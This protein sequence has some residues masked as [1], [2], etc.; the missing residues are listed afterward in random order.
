MWPALRSSLQF[1]HNLTCLSSSRSLSGVWT[2]WGQRRGRRERWPAPSPGGWRPWVSPRGLLMRWMSCWAKRWAT[3]S[4]LRTAALPRQYSSK[5]ACWN[6]H[7]SSLFM[8]F[9]NWW[10]F[11]VSLHVFV[12]K[13]YVLWT[14]S[15]DRNVLTFYKP[16]N[17]E[18]IIIE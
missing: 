12:S 15:E 6:I 10:R 14:A 17:L 13:S 3:P 11:L 1:K 4:G 9:D 16:T 18:K 8:F 2:W 5:K 7:L